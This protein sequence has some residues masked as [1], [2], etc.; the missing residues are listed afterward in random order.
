MTLPPIEFQG[1]HHAP[2]PEMT[3][4]IGP[5][6]LWSSVSPAVGGGQALAKLT[7]P[8]RSL[9]CSWPVGWMHWSAGPQ[10]PANGAF[11]SH[12]SNDWCSFVSAFF[13]FFPQAHFAMLL[14]LAVRFYGKEFVFSPLALSPSQWSFFLTSLASSSWWPLAIKVIDIAT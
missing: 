4:W 9:V 1:R 13:R 14:Q 3:S 2:Y 5:N 7:L 6:S 11:H 10:T 12:A 8:K